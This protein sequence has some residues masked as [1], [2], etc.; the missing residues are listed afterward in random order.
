MTSV[1]ASRF[2]N[3]QSRWAAGTDALQSAINRRW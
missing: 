1:E 3:P 2:L